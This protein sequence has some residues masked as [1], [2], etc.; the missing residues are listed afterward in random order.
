MHWNTGNK[1]KGLMISEFMQVLVS[2]L[3][4]QQFSSLLSNKEQ[5]Y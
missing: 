3:T 4:L 5:G 1:P 2:F